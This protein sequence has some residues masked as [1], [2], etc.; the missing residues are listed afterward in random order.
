MVYC[1]FSNIFFGNLTKLFTNYFQGKASVLNFLTTFH[2]YLYVI[3]TRINTCK[4]AINIAFLTQS[5][6]NFFTHDALLFRSKIKP[7]MHSVRNLIKIEIISRINPNR[8]ITGLQNIK[9][10][11]HEYAMPYL[12]N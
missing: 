5:I 4:I 3:Y 10:F 12:Y 9:V 2:D 1:F 6:H 11:F 8:Y 7:S